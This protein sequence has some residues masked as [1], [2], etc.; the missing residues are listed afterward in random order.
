MSAW[1]PPLV[2]DVEVAK[3][4]KAFEQFDSICKKVKSYNAEFS[5]LPNPQQLEMSSVKR[6]WRAERTKLHDALFEHRKVP[7]AIAKLAADIFYDSICPAAEVDMKLGYASVD[8]QPSKL[9][10]DW[11]EPF[12][13]G[14]EDS[15]DTAPTKIHTQCWA[16]FETLL[17]SA[18]YAA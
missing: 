7:H 13:V 11:H 9:D 12:F 15:Y 2:V 4:E 10:V 6:H 16:V 14:S 8:L 1:L 18:E 5:K 17:G 3:F